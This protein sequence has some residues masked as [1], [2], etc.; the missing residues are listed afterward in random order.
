M[1]N[2]LA[3]LALESEAATATMAR[4]AR[5]YDEAQGSADARRFARLATAVCKYWL[6]KRAPVHAAEAL[7]CFGGNGYVEEAPMARLYRE[8]PLNG[9]WE[10][11]GN[12]ICLDVLRAMGKDPESVDL[13]FAEIARDPRLD[14]EVE[15][16]RKQLADH[17]G[18]EQRARRLV[19]RLAILWQASLL[20]RHAPAFVADAFV[21]SRLDGDRGLA[22]G[23]LPRD[24]DFTAIIDRAAP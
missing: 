13:F 22:F 12:V 20:V 2:V 5:A 8:A 16:L 24:T 15:R 6:C 9:I 18:V 3:D 11:S 4:L 17:A 23:T 21:A 7:E 14:A 1:Q 19:E 10:G